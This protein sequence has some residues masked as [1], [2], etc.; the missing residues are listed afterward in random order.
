M[1]TVYESNRFAFQVSWGSIL[2]GSAV[3]LVTYLIFSVLGTAVGAQAV[4]MMQKGNPLSGF[5]TGTGIW[6]LVSTLASLAAGAFVAG[7]TAPNRGGLHGLLSW[8]ITTL[9]TTW[10]VVSLASGVVGL[11]G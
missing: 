5:G 1:T 3:A 6:L 4:D 7:R 9:L 8:A 10:L 11:A 2:A